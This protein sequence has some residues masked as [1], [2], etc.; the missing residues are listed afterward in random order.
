MV[1]RPSQPWW[2]TSTP[3]LRNT[4]PVSVCVSGTLDAA[5]E[6]AV[7]GSRV[8]TSRQEMIEDLEEM[9]NV[10]GSLSIIERG[11]LTPL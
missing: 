3:T 7:T 5:V 8:Q 4:L 1:G 11:R 2:L 6:Y 10:R 9:S